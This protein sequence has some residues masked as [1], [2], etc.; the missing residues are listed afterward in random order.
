MA[1]APLGTSGALA[2]LSPAMAGILDG[3]G[4]SEAVKRLVVIGLVAVGMIALSGRL[5]AALAKLMERM[6]E[7]VMP[8]MMDSCFAQMDPERRKFMLTH[9][10]G[11]LDRVEEKYVTAEAT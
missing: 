1:V 9:C 6:M 11:M 8:K 5:R 3:R 2:D 10:R 7:N 4:R